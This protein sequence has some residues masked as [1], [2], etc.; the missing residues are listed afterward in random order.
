MKKCII[1]FAWLFYTGNETEANAQLKDWQP[2]PVYP[3][4]KVIIDQPRSTSSNISLSE[5]E[6]LDLKKKVE[7][8]IEKQRP[9]YASLDTLLRASGLNFEGISSTALGNNIESIL[10]PL[11][12]YGYKQFVEKEYKKEDALIQEFK[13]KILSYVNNALLSGTV[14]DEVNKRIKAFSNDLVFKFNSYLPDA[15]ENLNTELTGYLEKSLG[16]DRWSRL[17]NELSEDAANIIGIPKALKDGLTAYLEPKLKAFEDISY[18]SGQINIIQGAL[19][20]KSPEQTFLLMQKSDLYQKLIDVA[21]LK[22]INSFLKTTVGLAGDLK[23]LQQIYSSDGNPLTKA[24]GTFTILEKNLKMF[25]PEASAELSK[26]LGVVD[27]A[28]QMTKMNLYASM[29]SI[30]INSGLIPMS[31]NDKKNANLLLNGGMAIFSFYSGNILGGITGTMGVLEGLFGGSKSDNGMAKMQM[32]IQQTMIDMTKVVMKGFDAL[33]NNMGIMNENMNTNYEN[34]SKEILEGRKESLK[35]A[36]ALSKQF[37]EGFMEIQKGQKIISEQV[38]NLHEDIIQLHQQTSLKLNV[39][40]KKIEILS[41]QN[42]CLLQIAQE[43]AL[44]QLITC[45]GVCSSNV[46]RNNPRTLAEYNEI[47]TKETQQCFQAFKDFINLKNPATNFIDYSQCTASRGGTDP[48]ADPKIIFDQLRLLW[49]TSFGKPESYLSLL[50]PSVSVKDDYNIAA[51]IRRNSNTLSS[52]TDSGIDPQQL[53]NDKDLLNNTVFVDEI[54]NWYLQIFPFR[55]V[56]DK[57]TGGRKDDTDLRKT[58]GPDEAR[59]VLTELEYLHTILQNTIAQQSLMSGTML[60]NNLYGKLKEGSYT[61]QKS[62][63][64]VLS[65]NYLLK[66]NLGKFICELNNPDADG[67]RIIPSKRMMIL[68]LK[69]S[70]RPSF[71]IF[72][73]KDESQDLIKLYEENKYDIGKMITQLFL[74]CEA[75]GLNDEITCSSLE[76]PERLLPPNF[77][78]LLELHKEYTNLISEIKSLQTLPADELNKMKAVYLN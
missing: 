57:Y 46:K 25:F 58:I 10:A 47:F 24:L 21:D 19:T 36:N 14:K 34:L 18:Y 26:A 12:S 53:L 42:G 9:A 37:Q 13:G 64:E 63:M 17:K 15:V 22:G 65:N 2:S 50:N 71:L 11:Q 23:Q 3:I 78:S 8:A 51:T 38:H 48:F 41:Q 5:K 52:G 68:K 43:A 73:V 32:E 55:A 27:N 60:L 29:G 61:E 28:K 40:D 45:R 4:D 59:E 20:G 54:A 70:G 72:L 39:I 77:Y 1:V 62:V 66:I 76:N 67:N 56:R 16:T 7:D 33:N 30:A 44:Q 6:F 35:Y 75:I 69:V 74:D 49:K 31:E